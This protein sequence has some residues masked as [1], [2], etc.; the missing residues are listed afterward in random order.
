MKG[1]ASARKFC[2]LL[3]LA[4]LAWTADA[5]AAGT[6]V[7]VQSGHAAPVTA[8]AVSADGGRLYSG[9][10]A[11]TIVAWNAAEGRQQRTLRSELHVVRN[12]ALTPDG[13]TLVA[14]GSIDEGI[15]NRSRLVVFDAASGERLRSILTGNKAFSRMA[16]SPDGTFVATNVG[17][18]SFGASAVAVFRVKD[19]KRV[20]LLK[21][22]GNKDPI[23][24]AFMP[25]GRILAGGLDKRL[26]LYDWKRHRGVWSVQRK[27]LVAEIAVSPDGRLAAVS[28]GLTLGDKDRRV[29]VYDTA[30]GHELRALPAGVNGPVHLAF[31]AD[32]RTLAAGEEQNMLGVLM[33]LDSGAPRGRLLAWRT[34]GWEEMVASQALSGSG[35][36]GALALHPRADEAFVAQGGSEIRRILL[37]K[38]RIARVEPMLEAARSRPDVLARLGWVMRE[39]K[40]VEAL[41]ARHGGNCVALWTDKTT[42]EIRSASGQAIVGK[43]TLAG[44]TD[45]FEDI[46]LD[47]QCSRLYRATYDYGDKTTVSVEERVFAGGPLGSL[48]QA[49][50]G[51]RRIG[52]NAFSQMA[53]RLELLFPNRARTALLLLAKTADE[54]RRGMP[55][56]LFT[57]DLD[58]GGLRRLLAPDEGSLFAAVDETAG[59]TVVAVDSS[60]LVREVDPSSGKVARS[61]R[62][63]GLVEMAFMLENSRRLVVVYSH[64]ATALVDLDTGEE[65][66]RTQLPLP[67]RAPFGVRITGMRAAKNGEIALAADADFAREVFR[68]RPQEAA[69]LA[70]GASP[71]VQRRFAPHRSLQIA[72]GAGDRLAT[73]DD[74]RFLRLWNLASGELV[75]QSPFD[76]GTFG[77][78]ALSANGASGALAS[79]IGLPL[80]AA[81]LGAPPGAA[82]TKVVMT[83]PDRPPEIK[84]LKLPGALMKDGARPLGARLLAD[85]RHALVAFQEKGSGNGHL[86]LLD[87][88]KGSPVLEYTQLVAGPLVALNVSRNGQWLAVLTSRPDGIHGEHH[89][90]GLELRNV[91]SG[92]SIGRRT[93]RLGLSSGTQVYA[94]DDGRHLLFADAAFGEI[95]LFDMTSDAPPQRVGVHPLVTSLDLD[96]SGSLLLSAGNDQ[97][98]RVWQ[99]SRPGAPALRLE[100]HAGGI[101]VARFTRDGRRIVSAGEDGTIRLWNAASGQE[102]A[103]FM[104][105][106]AGQWLAMTP[107]GYFAGSPDAVAAVSVRLGGKLYSLDQFYDV[108][109]R[110]DLVRRKLAGEDL[111]PYIKVTAEDAVKQPPPAVSIEPVPPLVEAERLTVRYSIAD[112]GGG[113]GDVRVYL[114]GKLVDSR[115]SVRPAPAVRVNGAVE[116][117]PIAG[118]NRISITAFNRDNSLQGAPQSAVF[119]SS[120]RPEPPRLFFLGIGI[121]RYR[122]ASADL[123]YAA[124]DARQFEQALVRD[125]Q[126]IFGAARIEPAAMLLD[127]AATKLAIAE[128]A[129][130]LARRMKPQD[131][132]VAFIA[133][134]G[135]L[136][137]GRYSIVTHDYAGE[138]NGENTMSAREILG[139]SSA[140]PAQHQ[141]WVFDTCHAGGVN[142]LF[143]ALYDARLSVLARS[144]GLHLFASAQT[145]EEALDGY[146]G[147]G[148]FTHV[149]LRGMSSAD[150]NRDGKVSASELGVFSRTEATHLARRIGFSQSP[151]I[152]RFGEDMMLSV[153][154]REQPQKK[155]DVRR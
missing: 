133:S 4:A 117:A 88:D 44:A 74:D 113:I 43:L 29:R 92:A 54:D 145:Q 68:W 119:R 24:V 25:D 12:L 139:L 135:V 58:T 121:S 69:V 108:F 153:A 82:L 79:S 86:F 81:T 105:G 91:W 95:R 154:K 59:G 23:G 61:F 114:N 20:A 126:G 130:A 5:A 102:I 52:T 21:V 10:A 93:F 16:I 78:D 22:F 13:A 141:L 65:I 142:E 90:T 149:L 77:G 155:A 27:A 40:L 115:R 73:A 138:L 134:H 125:A 110:P 97:Y 49:V 34:A 85:S 11:G 107:E 147:N 66:D 128:Q 9:D 26:Q 39:G 55:E 50:L 123:T 60:G 30:S 144:A 99:L 62:L 37:E 35:G 124:K 83:S 120:L 19:G 71:A 75:A 127:G 109:Y 31:S 63:P 48:R 80:A 17:K 140:M 151:V 72:L 100:G 101:Y 3:A 84:S 15:G 118:E 45:D 8:L 36:I 64:F 136:E 67:R 56:S 38:M 143:R 1:I 18:T 33:A 106:G 112:S 41:P 6:G 2:P 111:R 98:I 148:L 14:D 70:A 94:L 57:L 104:A 87:V 28:S 89:D 103:R 129:R 146:R 51:S 122:D 152:A 131:V 46:A 53:G 32:G 76:L 137:D 116:V 7:F 47:T 132:L 150:G 42:L 96:P